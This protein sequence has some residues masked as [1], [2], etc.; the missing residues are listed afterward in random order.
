MREEQSVPITFASPAAGGMDGKS[1]GC[2]AS[3][4]ATPCAGD[5]T[6][7]RQA[8]GAGPAGW[9]GLA[10]VQW[11]GGKCTG[12]RGHTILDYLGCAFEEERLVRRHLVKHHFLDGRF[13]APPQPQQQDPWLGLAPG[14]AA[15]AAEA[16]AVRGAGEQG[17]NA[18]RERGRWRSRVAVLAAGPPTCAARQE[19][20][21]GSGSSSGGGGGRVVGWGWSGSSGGGAARSRPGHTAERSH[22][23]WP[24]RW[25]CVPTLVL[26]S[27]IE[28]RSV[29]LEGIMAVNKNQFMTYSI[30][31][32]HI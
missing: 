26:I 22:L 32:L 15:E 31:I 14:A 29:R 4:T 13:A 17:T 8:S 12:G 6:A 16:A 9:R 3:A 10:K 19:Q 21:S 28:L 18:A 27:E 20:C 1:G 24:N 2:W 23:R 7:E 25:C 30:N 5:Q 11:T